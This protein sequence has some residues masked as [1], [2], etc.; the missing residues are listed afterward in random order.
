MYDEFAARVGERRRDGD[1]IGIGYV[2]LG[3]L[4]VVVWGLKKGMEGRII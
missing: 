2:D 4:N 1:G 3:C